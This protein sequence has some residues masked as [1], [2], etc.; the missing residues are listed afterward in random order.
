MSLEATL[1][2][3]TYGQCTIE[4]DNDTC[5][6][7]SRKPQML[8]TNEICAE[9]PNGTLH[10]FKLPAGAKYYFHPPT[11]FYPHPGYCPMF[12]RAAAGGYWT[13]KYRNA[14]LIVGVETESETSSEQI[15]R[16][17]LQHAVTKQEDM[18]RYRKTHKKFEPIGN[19]T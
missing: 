2:C 4:I 14:W 11:L 18:I 1:A 17:H 12:S 15:I 10:A 7:M 19:Y 5:L 9:L 8:F 16:L 3:P 6:F 13:L